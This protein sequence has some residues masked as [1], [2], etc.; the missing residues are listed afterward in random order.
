MTPLFLY[1][2]KASI[3]V[4][5]F[6]LFYRIVMNNDTFFTWKRYLLLASLLFS[7]VYPLI[8]ISALL[9]FNEPVI[10]IMNDYNQA[11]PVITIRGNN[12]SW[13]SFSSYT[14]FI[15][16]IYWFGVTALLIRLCVQLFSIIRLLRKGK[17]EQLNHLL[18]IRINGN[19]QPFSFFHWIFI[20]P[21]LHNKEDLDEILKHEE[22]HLQERHSVDVIFSELIAIFLWFNPF[23]WLMK[24]AIRQNLEFLADHCV[25]HSGFNSHN[26][27]I[28]LLRLSHNPAAATLV[29][30]FNVSELKKRIIM[31]NKKRSSLFGLTK[32]TLF[33]PIASLLLFSNQAKAFAT[34]I[35]NSASKSIEASL[36]N[37]SDNYDNQQVSSTKRK[38]SV[39]KTDASTSSADDTKIYTS[40]ET[41]PVYPGGSGAIMK[42]IQK[43]LQY[44]TAALENKISGMVIVRFVID[45]E[46]NVIKPEVTKKVDPLLDNEALRVI[47]RMGKWVP[48]VQG[49]KKVAAYMTLPI[50]FTLSSNSAI[51]KVNE[52]TLP[53]YVLDGKTISSEEMK[54]IDP[55][56]IESMNVLKGKAA[57]DIYGEKGTNGVVVI[58]SKK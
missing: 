23:I 8:D 47:G 24:N 48:A 33:L 15:I 39:K 55:N 29:N 41:P 11:L 45:K 10:T 22:T 5:V 51:Q 42:V 58:I 7:I 54:K 18:I 57:T 43:N 20:N 38:S 2:F 28:H 32:Y 12:E 21:E 52:S 3:A 4:A 9:A 16:F 13:W 25:I 30:N 31:M 36:S 19:I 44:P 37:A 14:H 49:G 46:G 17:R 56:T 26:Y 35:E 34:K 50:N 1:F 53:L 27:Q 40:T 6:Y